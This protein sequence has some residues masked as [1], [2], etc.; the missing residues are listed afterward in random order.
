MDRAQAWKAAC[1]KAK[2]ALKAGERSE[3]RRYARLAVKIAPDKEDPWLILAATAAPAASLGYLKQAQ[4]INPESARARKGIQW[5]EQ[6][7]AAEKDRA[8]EM[9]PGPGEAISLSPQIG[10]LVLA[11][12]AMLTLA[13]A[14]FVSLR[15]PAVDDGLRAAGAAAAK[16]INS[17]FA[18]ETPTPTATFTPT[19]TATNTPTS[20]P[21]NTPTPTATPTNTPTA[22]PTPTN[23]LPPPPTNT[24]PPP[25]PD[26]PA[27]I[28]D[29]ERWID[30]NLS[31]QTL[32]AF[33]GDELLRTYVIS[34]GRSGTPTVTGVFS[35][36][37]K[38]RIQDMSGPGY[39]IQ[40]VPW[41]MYFYEDYGIHGTWW[42]NNFGT[43]MSSGCVNMTIPDA[44]WMYSWASVG[45]IVQV[46]Y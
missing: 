38:V 46:H 14:A 25:A 15:P 23:T 1:I 36:W 16:S 42:H 29:N 18:T 13:F 27:G 35:I 19:N 21:T 12:L 43:P 9:A 45:T 44:E 39:Y 26:I 3:A 30:I 41:V 2:Q 28:G 22:S 8:A 5:A 24:P 11:T 4:A 6:R 20:T 17:I 7:M 37:V 31:T 33:E 40:D 34:S 32:Q 10:N